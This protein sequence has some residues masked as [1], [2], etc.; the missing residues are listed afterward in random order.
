MDSSVH[1]RVDAACS[2]TH[3]WSTAWR[4]EKVEGQ[5][6]WSYLQRRMEHGHYENLMK[7][8][9]RECPQ[10]YRNLIRK[11]KS[12][13]EEIVERVTHII[14]RKPIW[15][16]PI[17]PGELWWVAVTLRFLV[18]SNSYKSLQCAFRV[19][20]NT[21]SHIG[22]DTCQAIIAVYGD[23]VRTPASPAEWKGL[24]M[25]MRSVGTYLTVLEKLMANTC[26]SK[27]QSSMAPTSSAT[28]STFPWWSWQ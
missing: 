15:G 23:E 5:E 18:T 8:L 20:Q 10:M 17:S 3:P 19:V 6:A 12:L 21:I 14:Q 16:Q 1:E 28:R 24:S 27:I 9:A 25:S 22:P 2:S 7:E 11:D 26:A 13:F 4:E